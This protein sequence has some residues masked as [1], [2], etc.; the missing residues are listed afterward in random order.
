MATAPRRE[1][2]PTPEATAERTRAARALELIRGGQIRA[3]VAELFNLPT[4]DRRPGESLRAY[5]RRRLEDE[6]AVYAA[7]QAKLDAADREDR[8]MASEMY[9]A[10][11]A[12]HGG[13]IFPDDE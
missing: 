7:E 8:R 2:P 1:S 10:R 12:T 4:N 3:G 5:Q 13:V 6:G 9:R 11:L